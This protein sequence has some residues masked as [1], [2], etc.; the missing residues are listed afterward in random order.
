MEVVVFI[1]EEKQGELHLSEGGLDWWPRATKK[2]KCTKSW[3]Q[4]RTFMES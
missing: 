3:D 2:Y 4:L 1:D